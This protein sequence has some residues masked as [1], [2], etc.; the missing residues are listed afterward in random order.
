MNKIWRS[1]NVADFVNLFKDYI[2]IQEDTISTKS[3]VAFHTRPSTFEE[4]RPRHLSVITNPEGLGIHYEAYVDPNN[5]NR[6]S[7]LR[8]SVPGTQHAATINCTDFTVSG[9]QRLIHV[10]KNALE[11]DLQ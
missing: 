3:V 4:H 2:D 5:D 10:T 7:L 1:R 11:H 8:L 6:L 9:S